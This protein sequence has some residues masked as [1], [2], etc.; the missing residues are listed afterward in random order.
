MEKARGRVSVGL[1]NGGQ[2]PRRELHV[3]RLEFSDA[4]VKGEKKEDAHGG[5]KT[6][7]GPSKPIP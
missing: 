6:D 3:W 5:G 2:V 7:Y 1:P 4:D